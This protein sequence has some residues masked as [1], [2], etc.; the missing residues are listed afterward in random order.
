MQTGSR[1]L[2]KKVLETA[3]KNS[4]VRVLF[5]VHTP[6]PQGPIL[7]SPFPFLGDLRGR[8]EGEKN[9]SSRTLAG[10]SSHFRNSRKHSGLPPLFGLAVQL[11]ARI[12]WR[13]ESRFLGCH[14]PWVG[15]LLVF[16]SPFPNPETLGSDG[17][18][19]S[20]WV[21]SCLFSKHR[22]A[23]SSLPSLWELA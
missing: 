19:R 5:S 23:Q 21:F 11:V 16:L 6:G 22:F 10:C 7:R 15:S 9:A 1:L 4:G 3:W 20:V 18:S 14:E 13:T 2:L 12:R 17:P 8:G